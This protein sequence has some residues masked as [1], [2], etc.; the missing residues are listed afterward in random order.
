MKALIGVITV[1]LLIIGCATKDTDMHPVLSKSVVNSA[2]WMG[3][4]IVTP[5]EASTE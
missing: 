5:A 2:Q 4:F 3:G 1:L